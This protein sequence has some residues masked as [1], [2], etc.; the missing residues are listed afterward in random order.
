[1]ATVSRH[2]DKEPANSHT[3][4]LMVA[5]APVARAATSADFN[6]G[7]S[8]HG[9]F[10]NTMPRRSRQRP[11]IRGSGTRGSC[12]GESV[13]PRTRV[14]TAC[15]VRACTRSPP[16]AGIDSTAIRRWGSVSTS[17]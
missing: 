10:A 17:R 5:T 6:P 7:T 2:H 9:R 15:R 13:M 3:V 1:M 4:E 8:S 16:S 14:R 11:V 12:P